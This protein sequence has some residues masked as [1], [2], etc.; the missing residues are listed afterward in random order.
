MLSDLLSI[1]GWTLNENSVLVLL[2]ARFGFLPGR[3]ARGSGG[4]MDEARSG[5][6]EYAVYEKVATDATG[7]VIWA[8]VAAGLVWLLSKVWLMGAKVC[9]WGGVVLETVNVLHL[10]FVTA[11]GVFVHIS[12]AIVH[13]KRPGRSWL[14]AGNVVRLVEVALSLVALW[15]AAKAVGYF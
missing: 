3:G 10:L 4:V 15:L 5:E 8:F 7:N 11:A 14:W 1:L 13:K 2:W 12:D 6:V 9:F